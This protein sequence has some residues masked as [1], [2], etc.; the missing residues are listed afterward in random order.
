MNK[1]PI[2][3]IKERS[4]IAQFKEQATAWVQVVGFEKNSSTPEFFDINTNAVDNALKPFNLPALVCS[5]PRPSF[6]S[7]LSTAFFDYYHLTHI[8][9]VD[10]SDNINN[11][12]VSV[13]DLK[14]FLGLTDNKLKNSK[15]CILSI[16]LANTCNYSTT[17]GAARLV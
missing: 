1:D 3:T 14:N 11:W 7:N 9:D 12:R 5:Q 17:K 4:D 6:Q 16:K 2:T 8:E 13:G 10:P 15:Y